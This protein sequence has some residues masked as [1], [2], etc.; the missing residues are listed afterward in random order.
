M[1]IVNYEGK[2][3][4]PLTEEENKSYKKQEQCHICE[5]TN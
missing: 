4:I 3:M 2:E 1:K 5:E